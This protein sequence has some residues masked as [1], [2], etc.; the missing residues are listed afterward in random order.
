[1]KSEQGHQR[2]IGIPQ[3]PDMSLDLPLEEILDEPL[4]ASQS[5][6]VLVS[7]SSTGW[8]FSQLK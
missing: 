5:S 2:A 6:G 1:M 7:C 3:V 8:T 4:N